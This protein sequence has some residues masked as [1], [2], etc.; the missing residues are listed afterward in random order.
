LKP[1]LA[2]EDAFAVLG[3]ALP[4]G[5]FVLV[6]G[7]A[8]NLWLLLYRETEPTLSD[9][10]AVT[11]DDVDFQGTY[12]EAQRIHDA[13]KGSRLELGDFKSGTF[14]TA[15]VTFRDPAGNERQLDVLR[16]IHG[17]LSPEDVREAAVSVQLR[18]RDGHLTDTWVRV[19]HPLHCL[20]SRFYNTHSLPKY[21]S[22]RGIRQARA[23]LGCA[24][25]YLRQ[26][27]EE[28][29]RRKALAGVEIVAELACSDAGRAVK[30]RH[31]LD[32]LDAIPLDDRLGEKF[33][34]EYMPRLRAELG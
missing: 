34:T 8:L 13:L 18:D 27:C 28:G 32:A 4:D 15:I 11:S 17:P 6:G 7:Q 14:V 16:S 1:P 19:L 26:L 5:G 21:Q 33:L 22:D 23:A 3:P 12:A 10:G 20:V 30:K 2:F 31:A 9:I 29:E 24:R 25:A